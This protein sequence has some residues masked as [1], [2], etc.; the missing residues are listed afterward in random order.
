MCAVPVRLF[1]AVSACPS[2][3]VEARLPLLH[4]FCPGHWLVFRAHCP[5]S[6]SPHPPLPGCPDLAFLRSAQPPVEWASS[7]DRW[8]AGP[9]PT[10]SGSA[11]ETSQTL[12][13]S[14]A[15]HPVE[16]SQIGWGQAYACLHLGPLEIP[17]TRA[18]SPCS[19][20][21]SRTPQ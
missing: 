14:A 19:Q 7:S 12:S 2:G 10:L 11:R 4:P 9:I 6:L 3:R 17:N 8:Y 16:V 5:I 18:A 21:I 1:R 20:E 13:R 15:C